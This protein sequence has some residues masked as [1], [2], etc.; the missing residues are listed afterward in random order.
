MSKNRNNYREFYK[1]QRV[2]ESTHET[3]E[4]VQAVKEAAEASQEEATAEESKVEDI[5]EPVRKFAVIGGAE[6]VNLRQQPNKDAKIIKAYPKGTEVEV[7]ETVN[8]AWAKIAIKE[9]IGYMM[10]QYLMRVE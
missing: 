7:L 3:V 5:Q 9:Q 10:S 8:K 1:P 4:E 6:K 2:E